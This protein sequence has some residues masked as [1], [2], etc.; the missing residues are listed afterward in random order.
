[1][2]EGSLELNLLGQQHAVAKDVSAH[3]ANTDDGERFALR[4]ATHLS[5]VALDGFPC[6]PGG[7]A[8]FFVVVADRA[9]GS[10]GVTQPEAVFNGNAVG[11]VGEGGC[12]LVGG[13]DEIG[14]VS[15]A[16]TNAL[17]RH[18]LA[19]DQVVGEVEHAADQRRIAGNAFSQECIAIAGRWQALADE[20]TF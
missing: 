14:V 1:M 7:N 15:I 9:A 19:V 16:A 3:V 17:W 6:T 4:V 20:A 2:V 10:E 11:D 8:H 13:D 12:A 18:D 5:E